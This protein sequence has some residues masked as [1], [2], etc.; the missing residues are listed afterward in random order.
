VNLEVV[1]LSDSIGV[2]VRGVALDHPLDPATAAELRRLFDTYYLLLF[3]DQD[4]SEQSQIELC[5]VLRPVVDPIAWI[6]NVVP[7]FHPEGHLQFHCDYAFTDHPMLGLSLYAIDLAE[8]AAPTIF[9][10]NVLA[11]R[12]MPAEL[13]ERLRGLEIVH[14]IDSVGPRQNVRTRL[15]DVGATASPR[16][17]PRAAR[18]ALWTHPVLGVPLVF[19]L[20][21]QASH[22]VGMS[23]DESAPLIEEVFARL[24]RPE[25]SYE[26][27]WSQR[28]FV[29]WDNLA[30]QHGRRA[31]P[32]TVRRS[33][34]RV[35]MNT[36]TTADLN[37]GTG[38]DPLWRAQRAAG[39]VS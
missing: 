27:T 2:E 24:Y 34:R 8:G 35:A 21:Q 3:R 17:Y 18:P 15:D 4:L 5:R 1:P 28:D 38:F 32:N 23:C 36:V 19:V 33:L 9:V 12:T 20:E 37:V 16:E 29:V 39:T 11:Y 14:L 7:G 25:H 31:N 22:F 26:H 6:S 10:N 30:L 13:R